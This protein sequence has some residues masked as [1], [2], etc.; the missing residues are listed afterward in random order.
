MN[1]EEYMKQA[2]AL[3]EHGRGQ[4][5]PNPM[6]GAMVV[7]DGEVAGIGAHL[8]AGTPH[9]EVHAIRMAGEKA[10]GSTVYV[11]LEPCSHYGRTPPCAD[12]LIQSRIKKAVIA[13]VDPN[14]EVAGRG[15]QKLKNAGIE[16]TVGILEEEAKEL[17]AFFFHFIKTKTPY[18]TLKSAASMDG[19]TAASSGDSKW[20]TGEAAREDVHRLRELHD[21]ILCGVDTVIH[22]DPSLTCRIPGAKRQPVRIILD[23]HCRI[24]KNAKVLT[25]E[26]SRTWIVAGSKADSRKINGLIESGAEVLQMDQEDIRIPDLLKLLGEKGITSLLVEGGSTVMGSFIEARAFKRMIL[27]MAPKLII[28]R[29]ALPIAGGVGPQTMKE[30]GSLV[31]KD[32]SMIGNDLRITAEPV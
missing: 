31:F 5:A 13:T 17:N 18:V 22:D 11:T 12:L 24:P 2:L 26:E 15:I 6:V 29:D 9:A 30:A 7:K 20:I 1:D 32:V 28:G 19:K 25:D 8:K 14:P 3:A 10:K 16:V 27:Y 21:A 4:T 23:T